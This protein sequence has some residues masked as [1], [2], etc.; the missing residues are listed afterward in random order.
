[1]PVK[2]RHSETVPLEEVTAEG[3]QGVTIRWLITEEDPGA[4]RFVMRQFEVAPGGHTPRHRH[5]WEHEVYV[6]AGKGEVVTADGEITIRAGDAVLVPPHEEHQFLNTGPAP[7]R[8][9]C[10]IPAR[11]VCT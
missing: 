4:E 2:V 11:T 5:R 10:L 7:L 8:F 3:A 1:M 9:L 6:L